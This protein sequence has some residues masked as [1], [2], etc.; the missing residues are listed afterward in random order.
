MRAKFLCMKPLMEQPLHHDPSAF[1]LVN[2]NGKCA[3]AVTERDLDLNLI[4]IYTRIH[5][6]SDLD[7]HTKMS[8]FFVEWNAPYMTLK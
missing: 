7:L 4:W 2:L 1:C 6:E 3:Q 5:T 8:V